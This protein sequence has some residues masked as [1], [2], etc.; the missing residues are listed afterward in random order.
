VTNV[1]TAMQFNDYY[2]DPNPS[3]G[4]PIET[5]LPL[6]QNI[7]VF[8]LRGTL[9]SARNETVLGPADLKGVGSLF[10]LLILMINTLVPV[11]QNS[12]AHL[13]DLLVRI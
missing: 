1:E 8:G 9:G 3:C 2:G 5:K 12:C 6:I 11:Q 10:S 4:P 13:R 7:T